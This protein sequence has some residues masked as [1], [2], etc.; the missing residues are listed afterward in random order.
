MQESFSSIADTRQQV[1]GRYDL[2]DV[3]AVDF[4]HSV[5]DINTMVKYTKIVG[6]NHL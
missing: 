1:H 5:V 6:S 3:V 2:F 4:L